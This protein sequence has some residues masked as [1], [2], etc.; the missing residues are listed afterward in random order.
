MS[1]GSAI[2]TAPDSNASAI[3]RLICR[4]LGLPAEQLSLPLLELGI[5]NLDLFELIEGLEIALGQPIPVAQFSEIHCVAD[6]EKAVKSALE[7][8]ETRDRT[9][10]LRPHAAA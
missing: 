3:R 9:T 4:G 6:V 5:E 1:R 7:A 8:S 10:R 2:P